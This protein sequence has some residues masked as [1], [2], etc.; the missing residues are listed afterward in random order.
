MAEGDDTDTAEVNP[1]SNAEASTV[2]AALHRFD[3][4]RAKTASYLG[5]DKT[6]LWRKMKK[7][8]INYPL[9]K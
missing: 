4:H 2:W 6:T 9:R 8:E 1:L 3:G 5:I 7:Y